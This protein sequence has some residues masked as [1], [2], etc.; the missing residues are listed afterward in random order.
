MLYAWDANMDIQLA[1]DPFA[2]VTY[3]VSYMN[4]DETQTTKFMTEALKSAAKENAKEKLKKLKLAYFTHRQVGAS[5][6]VY[7]ILPNLKLKDSN[8]T[9]IFVMTG[10]PEKSFF[11]FQEGWRAK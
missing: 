9:C 1:L 7:R 4:K 2:V 5:E 3:I 10:F 11:I 6:A 8:I